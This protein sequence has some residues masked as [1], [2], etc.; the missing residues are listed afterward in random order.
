[1]ERESSI[2][3]AGA[4]G[5]KPVKIT[6]TACCPNGLKWIDDSRLVFDAIDNGKR[7]LWIMNRDGTGQQNLSSGKTDDW[8][9]SVSRGGRYLVFLS[10]RSGTRELWRTDID[11]RNPR[12]LTYGSDALWLPGISADGSAVYFTQFKDGMRVL[13]KKSVDGGEA[14]QVTKVQTDL[15]AISPDGTL[16]AYSFFDN[17]L[18]RQRLAAQPIEGGSTIYFDIFAND[19]LTWTP[20]STGLLY[21]DN[22][23]HHGA[24]S[25][26]WIQP[27]AGGKPRQLLNWAGEINYWA[28]WSPDGDHL[29]LIRGHTVANVVMLKGS[30]R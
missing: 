12:Q 23:P 27:I 24:D 26:L 6:T 21:K 11:G 13:M 19:V 9:P 3:I 2:Y 22:E 30:T 17:A 10:N 25:G 16:L 4:K 14:T 20:D 5:E 1:M 29:A 7:Q 8:Q 18:G 28:D 15:W